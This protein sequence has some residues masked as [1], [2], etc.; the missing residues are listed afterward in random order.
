MK[1]NQKSMIG[2]A[3]NILLITHYIEEG[4]GIPEKGNKTKGN[5]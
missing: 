4:A 2:F 3:I 5:F 1:L